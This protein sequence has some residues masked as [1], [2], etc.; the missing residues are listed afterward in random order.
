MV[1]KFINNCEV[2]AK[3]KIT[4]YTKEQY[5]ITETPNTSFEVITIDTVGPLIPSNNFRYILTLQCELTKFI[6]AIPLKNKEAIS[7]AKAIVEKFILKY[8]CFK[9]MKT[10]KGT[11]FTNELLKNI[12]KLLKIE[13]T[14]STPFHHE[15]LG[16]VERNHRVLNDYLMTMKS[17]D[18]W[19]ELLP[20]YVY[21]YN[22]TPHTTTN[23]TPFELIFMMEFVDLKS[24]RI[25]KEQKQV[26][27]QHMEEHKDFAHDRFVSDHGARS[28]NEQWSSLAAILNAVGGAVKDANGWKKAWVNMKSKSKKKVQDYKHAMGLT[29][30]ASVG[31]KDLTDLDERIIA[32]MHPVA[33]QGME[34]VCELAMHFESDISGCYDLE[35]LE[36][37]KELP[38]GSGPSVGGNDEGCVPIR[39]IPVQPSD[40]SEIPH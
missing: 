24:K 3:V 29:G 39:P 22:S 37:G 40:E 4:K 7:V 34:D 25:S 1:K 18:T 26:L 23:Y 38:S 17:V 13:K 35:C 30:N 16:T 31:I 15:T 6:E 9:K 2:C 5:D 28:L 33:V 12:C 8:G 10:D 27:V 32:V 36:E 20:Y 19:D 14:T 11:E 21:S